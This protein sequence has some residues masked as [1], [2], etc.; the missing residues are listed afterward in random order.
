MYRATAI[1]F[2]S[3]CFLITWEVKAAPGS[4]QY[5]LIS[6]TNT[7]PGQSPKVTFSV[8]NPGNGNQPYDIKTDPAFLHTPVSRLAV[9]IGWN[10][11]QYTNTGSRSE[12]AATPSAAQPISVDVLA[13]A[14]S[15]ADGTFTVTSP[16]PIP[17]DATG[18]GVALLEGRA[19][20]QDATGAYTVTIPVITA[21]TYF[22]ITGTATVPRRQIVD[23]NRCSTC[24]TTISVH[25]NNRTDQLMGC[26]VCHNTNATDIPYRQFA[27]GPEQPIEFKYMIHSIHAGTTRKKPYVVVG[28]GHS[29]NDFSKVQFPAPGLG[30]CEACHM[31][32]TYSVTAKAGQLGTT[33]ATNSV[34]TSTQKTVDNNPA[35]NLRITPI[36]AACSACHGG[37]AV[38]SH[39]LQNG[40]SLSVL[41]HNIDSGAVTER[42]GNCHG[43]G[44]AN[45]VVVAHLGTTSPTAPRLTSISRNSG[46]VNSSVDVTITGANLTGTTLNVGGGGITLS[47]FSAASG[48]VTA[49]LNIAAGAAVGVRTIKVSSAAGVSNGLLFTVSP[50]A[51]VL[52]SITPASGAAG[53][54]VSA[55]LAGSNLSG[56][57]IAVSGTGVTVGAT[58]ASGSQIIVVLNIGSS[59]AG[60]FAVTATTL[61][62]TSNGMVFTA[63]APSASA[64]ILSGI[65]PGTGAISSV[66]PV[67]LTGLNF[68]SGA[69]V[70]VSGSGVTAS[71]VNVVSASQITALLT[72]ASGA[73]VSSR[74][75][76]VT[77]NGTRSNSVGFSVIRPPAPTLTAPPS[78]NQG[79]LGQSVLITLTG[80]NF[81]PGGTRVNFTSGTGVTA[82]N[83]NVISSTKMTA[84]FVIAPNASLN[85][86]LFNV[87]TGGGSSSV[88]AFTVVAGTVP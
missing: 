81:V 20:G 72:I 26:V 31:P 2:I 21:Y 9:Q 54:S 6:V 43:Q 38:Q 40:G 14:V 52:T 18:T 28:F 16:L 12:F 32:G 41:Q 56:A 61:G 86:R 3:T 39:I 23:R 55:I 13:T 63:T 47:N 82:T 48:Q 71:N 34:L 1:L 88:R 37:T 62:G 29:I 69:T 19:A 85:G 4:Y 68:A 64:P 22:P 66:T 83:I 5:N 74:S 11:S 17:V 35:D 57:Q 25:G 73:T 44:K 15:N 30:T 7:Q 58:T 46:V 60:S 84:T 33:A 78:P 76:T 87:S 80:T 59:A 42:C 45:D 53:T 79:A 27:D 24:H 70:T 65:S 8:T 36:A 50:P 10:T 67:M 51:P 77:A 75:V 49:T